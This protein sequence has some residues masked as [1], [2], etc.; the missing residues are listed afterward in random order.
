MHK[1]DR[2]MLGKND[3]GFSGQALCVK[4]IA[5]AHGEEAT[6]NFQFGERVLATD[7]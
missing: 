1:D 5:E 3:I 2:C 7:G 4:A 6:T